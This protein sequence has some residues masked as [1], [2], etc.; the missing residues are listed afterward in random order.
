M[1]F[2]TL[3]LIGKAYNAARVNVQSFSKLTPE[4]TKNGIFLLN[5]LLS[6]KTVDPSMLLYWKKLDGVFE[7]AEKEYFLENLI[8]IQTL[9]YYMSDGT[10]RMPT[11]AQDMTVF[12]GAGRAENIETLPF[13]YWL[14]QSLGGSTLYVYPAPDQDYA[15]TIWGQ[16]QLSNVTLFEDLSLVFPMY[17]ILHLILELA[18]MICTFGAYSVPEELMLQLAK[19]RELIG[20]NGTVFDLSMRVLSTVNTSNYTNWAQINIDPSSVPG[21]I[22]SW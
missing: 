19:S 21:N 6:Q 20:N 14:N 8:S 2:N 12:N 4:Q 15:Y 22:T 17:Y 9:T 18:Y 10:V 16:F 1:S 11:L 7:A 5:A 13:T 3:E